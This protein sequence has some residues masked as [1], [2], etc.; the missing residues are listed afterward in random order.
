[1]KAFSYLAQTGLVSLH[2]SLCLLGGSARM[3]LL[4]PD[5]AAVGN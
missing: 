1:M 3:L 5:I 2:E 4:D